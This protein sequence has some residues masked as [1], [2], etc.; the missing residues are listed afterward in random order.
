MLICSLLRSNWLKFSERR[1]LYRNQML[2]YLKQSTAAELC[3]CEQ[4][5]TKNHLSWKWDEAMLRDEDKQ[6]APLP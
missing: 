1:K 6:V 2:F 3:I 4:R 5:Q